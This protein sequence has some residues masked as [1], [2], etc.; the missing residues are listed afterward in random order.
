MQVLASCTSTVR[1]GGL[2][3][4]SAHP[5][6]H[7]R[8]PLDA[9]RAGAPSLSVEPQFLR[10]VALRRRR[11]GSAGFPRLAVGRPLHLALQA[12][13]GTAA[14]RSPFPAGAVLLRHSRER[15]PLQLFRLSKRPLGVGNAPAPPSCASELPPA[16]F[17]VQRSRVPSSTGASTHAPASACG[18]QVNP[19][20][21]AASEAPARVHLDGS[22][23]AA[24]SPARQTP[25]F[26]AEGRTRVEA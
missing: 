12:R 24:H 6:C 11:S 22:A 18:H 21:R 8:D 23:G 5:P 16:A 20:Q 26:R 4:R 10:L 17:H 3:R 25:Y 13:P 19:L 9:R 14:L 7:P 2:R 1:V 15:V